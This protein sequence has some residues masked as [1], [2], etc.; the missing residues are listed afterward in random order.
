[1]GA[2]HILEAFRSSFDTLDSSENENPPSN[3]NYTENQ[4]SRAFL[5]PANFQEIPKTLNL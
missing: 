1:M 5:V 3:P 2:K 4:G